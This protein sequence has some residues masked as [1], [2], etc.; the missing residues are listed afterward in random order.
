LTFLS[1]RGLSKSY[2][3]VEALKE[4]DLDVF[5]GEVLAVC[6]DNGA[7]KSTLIRILS[8]AEN[9]SAG[10]VRLRGV[11]VD[12]RSPHQAL[13]EGV[14]AIYQHLA[15]APRLTVWEN[16]FVGAE[17][18]RPLLLP[19]LRI[20][21]KRA[22]ARAARTYLE[23]LDIAVEDMNTPVERL[24][25]G[26]RQAVAISRGLRWSAELLIMDEPTAALGVKETAQVIKLI[27]RMRAEGRTI[28]LVSHNMADVVASA[29]RV[30]VLKNGVKVADRPV[31]G[32][33]AERLARL[34]L[35]GREH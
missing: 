27:A 20:L 26:Q 3:G 2:G 21:D 6:G 22:M 34:I 16:I 18:T 14:A 8:G 5:K 25:G 29:S 28:I 19:W 33:D 35:V 4:L 10:E 7:G 32:L 31:A 11:T 13:R 23:R 9:R 1:L 24:S 30:L 17:L 15:L 12:F